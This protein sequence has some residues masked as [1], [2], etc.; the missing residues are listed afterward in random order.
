[1]LH[2]FFSTRRKLLN[3]ACLQDG[4]NEASRATLLGATHLE[5]YVDRL[6]DPFELAITT[7]ALISSG[8]SAKEASSLDRLNKMAK[9]SM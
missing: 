8:R 3:P 2:C 7:Y 1:M 9:T 6:Q 5:T 4:A